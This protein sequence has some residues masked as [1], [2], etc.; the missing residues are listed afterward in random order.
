MTSGRSVYINI[1]MA[2]DWNGLFSGAGF[3]IVSRAE[4]KFDLAPSCSPGRI[5]GQFRNKDAHELSV[6]YIDVCLR[7]F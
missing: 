5:A 6:G 4:T 1:F 2:L 3:E 7:N